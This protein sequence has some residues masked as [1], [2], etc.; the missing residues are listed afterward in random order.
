MYPNQYSTII[1]TSRS[2]SRDDS[3]RNG[4]VGNVAE[5]IPDLKWAMSCGNGP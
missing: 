3:E 1:M 5:M 4:K 2:E